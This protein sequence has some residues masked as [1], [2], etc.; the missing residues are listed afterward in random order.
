MGFFSG[1]GKV[2]GT[3]AKVA[4]VATGN[5]VL[6]AVGTG[7]DF[8]S[9]LDSQKQANQTNVDIAA[10]NNATSIDLANTAYQRRVKDLQVAG[11]NPMLAYGQGGAQV[12]NLQQ[13]RVEPTLSTAMNVAA[14]SAGIDKMRAETRAAETSSEVNSASAAKIKSET[15]GIDYSNNR[16]QYLKNVFDEWFTAGKKVNADRAK[17][18]LE[19]HKASNDWNTIGYLNE[20]AVKHGYRNFQTAL[21]SREFLQTIQNFES[22]AQDIQLRSFDKNR[23]SAESDVWGS[24][25]GR[26]VLPWVSTASDATKIGAGIKLIAK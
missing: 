23:K 18:I 14:Q 5:P 4:G 15:S 11:L 22:G 12:P 9:G 16:N 19:Q 24:P 17:A 8:V 21:D 10:A 2:L 7:L 6:S 25:V 26:R 13:A 3:V 20:F 1:I